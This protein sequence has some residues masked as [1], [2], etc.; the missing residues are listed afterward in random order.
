LKEKAVILET[1]GT[2]LF[3]SSGRCHE[4]ADREQESEASLHDDPLTPSGSG[5]AGPHSVAPE[6][7]KSKIG[8]APSIRKAGG[9]WPHG[10]G[11]KA[12]HGCVARIYEA[13]TVRRS[14]H[15]PQQPD[16]SLMLN[17]AAPPPPPI[18]EPWRIVAILLFTIGVMM[19]ARAITPTQAQVSGAPVSL[20]RIP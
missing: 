16:R 14:V 11:S 8:F 5:P 18:I 4:H 15:G 13:F 20:S 6:T 19:F 12:R 9:E 1:L 2:I 7:Q 17:D 10:S 3:S